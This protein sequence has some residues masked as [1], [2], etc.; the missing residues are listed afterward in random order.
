MRARDIVEMRREAIHLAFL[1]KPTKKQAARLKA[2][3]EQVD[4]ER[5]HPSG[6]ARHG[7]Q[8]PDFLGI[9]W[10]TRLSGGH[11][12]LRE[13]RRAMRFGQGEQ[14]KRSRRQRITRRRRTGGVR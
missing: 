3:A 10:R 13:R 11:M 8:K 9:Y 12:T 7:D 4:G 6:P 14:P 1:K 5:W 2:I